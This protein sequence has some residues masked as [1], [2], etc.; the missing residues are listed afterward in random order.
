MSK[1]QNITIE[2]DENDVRLDRWIKR[3]IVGLGQGQ[4]E[5]ALRRGDI[6]VDGKRAK[7]NTRLFTGM[8]V[9]LP[10]FT[11]SKAGPAVKSRVTAKDQSLVKSMVIFDDKQVLALNKISG[12]ATQ[13]GTGTVRHIDGM[14][15]AFDDLEYTPKLVHRLDRDTSGLLLLGRTPA[16]TASLAKA[17]KSR[18]AKKTYLAIV[19]GV[20][21]P[22]IGVIKGY[23]K[24]GIGEKGREMMIWARHGDRDAQ[25]SRTSYTVLSRAGQKAALVALRPETG[26][27]HQLRFH[28]AEIGY[29]VSGDHKYVCDREELGGLPNKL[30]LHAW[31]I[32]L[33]H[34]TSGKFQLN[35]PLPEHFTRAMDMLGFE[36]NIP[37]DPFEGLE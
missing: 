6:R 35:C 23:M 33:P 13:G 5:K 31:G 22:E 1:V 37:A 26:R 3:R 29:A 8:L 2:A 30:M 12:L 19:L 4:I 27:T 32:E 7:A 15:P 24:K 21:R 25:Y 28:L 17:F 36:S 16:A 11:V 18:S 14:L 9:R 20:P 10:P 34:P